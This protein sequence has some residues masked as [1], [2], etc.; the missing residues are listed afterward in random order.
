MMKR[1][2]FPTPAQQMDSRSPARC[3]HRVVSE[4][5]GTQREIGVLILVLAVVLVPGLLT[6]GCYYAS[7]TFT[8]PMSCDPVSPVCPPGTTC[9]AQGLCESSGGTDGDT[10][11]GSGSAGS[12]AV[13]C[14]GTAPFQVCLAAPTQPLNILRLQT[15]DT[16]DPSRCAVTV[17]KGSFGCVL[18]ATTITVGATLRAYGPR[19]LVLIASDTITITQTG[20]IDVG[21]HRG[22]AAGQEL[23]AGADPHDCTPGQPPMA[24]GGGAGGS[25]VGR[26]GKGGDSQLF[27]AWVGGMSGLPVAGDVNQLRGGCAGQNGGSSSNT[28]GGHGGG[29]VLLIASRAIGLANGGAINAAGEG[30]EG[31]LSFPSAAG[32]GGGSGGMIVLDAPTIESNGLILASGGGGGGGGSSNSSGIRGADPSAVLP[33][34]GGEGGQADGGQIDGGRG[35]NGSTSV[36]KAEGG[37]AL[38]G[39]TR[40]GASHGGGGGGGTGIVKALGAASLGSQVSPP[41]QT[42]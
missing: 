29:A 39:G 20:S 32:G 36:A 4:V 42:P 30:G 14:F 22:T 38:P 19:P 11:S 40:I 28:P 13:T 26:G 12:G 8:S 37:D 35:G 31:G 21:S 27:S 3:Y 5:A 33:A 16:A 18:A 15:I 7:P 34:A 24:G 2:I 1:T 25:F 6:T 41:M 17:P 9:S 23:G 10:G